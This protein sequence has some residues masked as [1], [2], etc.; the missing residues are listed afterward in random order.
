MDVAQKVGSLIESR[1]P[2]V[3]VE[4]VGST[5]VPGCAGKGIVDLMILYPTGTLPAVLDKLDDLGFQR[6]T[7]R[8]PFP[9]SRPMRTGSVDHDGTRF[10]LHAHVIATD[11]PEASEL[12]AFRERLRADR[13]LVDAYVARKRAILAEGITDSL[14]YCHLKGGFVGEVLEALRMDGGIPS[15][16]DESGDRR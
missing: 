13:S 9:E 6:Q 11:A 7:S 2:G 12:R 14:D 5:S 15:S 3:I 16:S 1:L 10:R 8:D 4:H